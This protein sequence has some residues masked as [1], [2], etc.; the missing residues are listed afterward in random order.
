MTFLGKT[1]LSFISLSSVRFH[2]FDRFAQFFRLLGER[3]IV[4]LAVCLLLPS[5]TVQLIS[6]LESIGIKAGLLFQQLINLLVTLSCS[7]ALHW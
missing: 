6:L 4:F 7:S 5:L 1:H 3:A 2:H